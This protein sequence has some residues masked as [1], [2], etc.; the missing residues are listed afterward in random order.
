MKSITS[1]R[2]REGE[3]LLQPIMESRKVKG[4]CTERMA[5]LYNGRQ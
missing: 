5:M 4:K 1:N 3:K 2:G